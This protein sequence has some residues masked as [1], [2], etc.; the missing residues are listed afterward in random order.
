MAA[1]RKGIAEIEGFADEHLRAFSTRRAEILEA[2]GADASAA[3]LP[4][5][6]PRHPQAE[7][8]DI[9]A[10]E[11]LQRWRTR[12]EE[13]G[14]DRETIERTLGGQGPGRAL[15]GPHACSSSAA[16][17]RRTASHFDRRDAIQA[18]ADAL[19]KGAPGAEVERLAD[20]FLACG[21]GD[22]DRRDC[23]R[24][25]LHHAANLGA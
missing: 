9:S 2:A 19:P 6:D 22:P 1:T 23:Q 15:P 16:P 7:G 5:G 12:A 3:S 24:P 8:R 14:L 11:L 17:S 18:V 4:G 13:I 25:P 20:A 21:V 10:V